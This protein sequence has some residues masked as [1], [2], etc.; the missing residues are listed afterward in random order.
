VSLPHV[1]TLCHILCLLQAEKQQKL[2]EVE[3]VVI[4][5][6]SQMQH[7]KKGANTMEKLSNS[8]LFSQKTLQKLYSRAA[9]LR[10]ETQIQ[11]DKHM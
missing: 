5:K 6:L 11:M 8:L 3:C 10:K 1:W 9:E 4:L 7:F 2:N